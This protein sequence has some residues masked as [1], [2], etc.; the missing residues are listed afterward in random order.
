MDKF[1]N[2]YEDMGDSFNEHI[3]E[4]GEKDTSIDRINV[5]GNY[6]KDN[7]KWSTVKEQGNNR[8]TN[9]YLYY[10]GKK[11]TLMKLSEEFNILYGTLKS[12]INKCK[13]PVNKAVETPIR[14]RSN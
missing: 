12:R 9:H 11:Y 3:K 10:K 2:F 7:C 1:E 8:R 14:K 4:F 13:W 6:C 5:S